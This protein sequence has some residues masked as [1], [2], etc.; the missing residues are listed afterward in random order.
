MRAREGADPPWVSGMCEVTGYGGRSHGAASRQFTLSTPSQGRKTRGCYARLVGQVHITNLHQGFS[1]AGDRTSL[2]QG[3]E[4]PA[5]LVTTP[6]ASD[7]INNKQK[8]AMNAHPLC[9]ISDRCG[10]C[11]CCSR[12]HLK[13]CRCPSL[14]HST[15]I[16]P[17]TARLLVLQRSLTPSPPKDTCSGEANS[18]TRV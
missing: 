4:A 15:A 2:T 14:M 5:T 8:H 17:G 18:R 3:M 7:H 11:M 10:S 16:I 13:R 6:V 1:W 12:G 9:E